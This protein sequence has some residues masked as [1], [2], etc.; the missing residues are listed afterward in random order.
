MIRPVKKSYLFS[1]KDW[2]NPG[3]GNTLFLI[4]NKP[5]V[6]AVGL[7]TKKETVCKNC[8]MFL[9]LTLERVKRK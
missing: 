9:Y 4:Q 2:T 3:K 7:Y 6:D 5:A 8:S 1:G